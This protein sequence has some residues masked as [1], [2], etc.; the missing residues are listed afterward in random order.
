MFTFSPLSLFGKEALLGHHKWP[1][2]IIRQQ[3]ANKLQA[4]ARGTDLIV[5]PVVLAFTDLV[6][7]G[8]VSTFSFCMMF[9]QIFHAWAHETKSKLP[10]L[11]VTLQDMGLI[12]SRREHVEHHRAPHNNNYCIMSGVWNKILNESKFFDAL[13][14]ILYFQFGVRP[15]SWTDRNSE[16][17]EETSISNNIDQA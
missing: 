6:F 14:K 8:F 11:V 1:W 16:V 7:H 12:L 10:P 3:F 13:E 15:R 4:L 5:L 2:R 17:T 9:S